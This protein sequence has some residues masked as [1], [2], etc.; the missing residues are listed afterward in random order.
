MNEHGCS[1]YVSLFFVIINTSY[2]DYKLNYD[3]NITIIFIFV[4]RLH[5]LHS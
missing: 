1:L 4:M 5:V 2:V 3:K